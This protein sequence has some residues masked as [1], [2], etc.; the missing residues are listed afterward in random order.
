MHH[1]V[2]PISCH[3]LLHLTVKSE[4]TPHP[5]PNPNLFVV[6]VV[7]VDGITVS[8]QTSDLTFRTR[9]VVADTI[10]RTGGWSKRTLCSCVNAAQTAET[11]QGFSHKHIR[12]HTG[13]M[14]LDVSVHYC[15]KTC[16][17]RVG[18]TSVSVSWPCYFE[19]LEPLLGCTCRQKPRWS[20]F[21]L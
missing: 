11:L 15:N 7:V 3:S 8:L 20:F 9:P 17:G 14:R 4:Q 19:I 1:G 18:C 10:V 2:N 21:L 12:A 16:R 5:P 13:E 6:V